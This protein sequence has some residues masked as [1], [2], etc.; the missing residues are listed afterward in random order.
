MT[1]LSV[2][3]GGLDYEAERIGEQLQD[4][5]RASQEV[6]YRFEGSLGRV[7]VDDKGTMISIL[8]GVVM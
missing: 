5:L 2:G 3:I 4:L 1:I 8:F 7:T 6:I